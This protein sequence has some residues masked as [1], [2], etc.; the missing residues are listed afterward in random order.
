MR[1]HP[2]RLGGAPAAPPEGL[3][4]V[5]PAPPRRGA[6]LEELFQRS[7]NG[8]GWRILRANSQQRE[9]PSDRRAG[10]TAPDRQ[11]AWR[12]VPAARGEHGSMKPSN[13][14]LFTRSLWFTAAIAAA[15]L[16]V[17]LLLVYD[18]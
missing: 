13:L 3:S 6:L 12:S 17:A 14:S 10:S 5:L 7:P 15:V 16:I 9:E 4:A 8:G 2:S 18:L 1:L 11:P